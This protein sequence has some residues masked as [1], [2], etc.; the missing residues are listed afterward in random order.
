MADVR[1]AVHI[2]AHVIEI[3]HLDGLYLDESRDG[4]FIASCVIGYL[5]AG[6]RMWLID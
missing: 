3:A 1:S 5:I 4:M 2:G 6:A